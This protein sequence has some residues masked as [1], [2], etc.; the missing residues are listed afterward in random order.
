MR[1]IR[2]LALGAVAALAVAVPAAAYPGA[3]AS[4]P[5]D[6]PANGPPANDASAGGGQPG[7]KPS[8]TAHWVA[9][10]KRRALT[11]RAEGR[12]EESVEEWMAVALLSGG[13]PSA[14][15]RAAVETIDAASTGR[16]FQ[17]SDPLYKLAEGMLY[18]VVRQGAMHDP[19]LAYVV[20]RMRMA[21]QAW[22]K[23][24]APLEFARRRGFDPV[25]AD[26]W[27]FRAA[28]NYGSWLT[29]HNRADDAIKILDR[30]L[31][32]LPQHPHHFVVRINLAHAHRQNNEHTIAETILRSDVLSVFPQCA[33]AWDL[34]GQVYGDQARLDEA[35]DAHR[36]AMD[37]A[38]E[39]DD[40]TFTGPAVFETA[41]YHA[42]A[43][44]LKAGRIEEAEALARQ[45]GRRKPDDCDA[46][47]LIGTVFQ[48][49]YDRSNSFEDLSE[50]VRCF[51]RAARFNREDQL[52]RVRLLAVLPGLPGTPEELASFA[53]EMKR[54]ETELRTLQKRKPGDK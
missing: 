19:S 1:V 15:L 12:I 20:G 26:Y 44:E 27:W 10:H 33:K 2:S 7:D 14:V 21:D 28:A 4:P 40:G 13:A 16:Y 30:A 38:Q 3:F 51:R 8:D 31:R 52:S 45:Y 47:F 50:A 18:D 46:E 48:A 37:L 34:L 5:D 11:L 36:R 17:S 29:D 39:S 35:L 43:T 49:K 32:D 24:Y 9:W 23:A 25:R 22:D 42:A 54:V 41:L 6:P 53:D